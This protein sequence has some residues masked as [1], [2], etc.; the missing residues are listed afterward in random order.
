MR[1][2]LPG[3]ISLQRN[4]QFTETNITVKKRINEI[5]LR[6]QQSNV[7]EIVAQQG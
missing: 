2:A 4:K 1:E 6:T 7:D 3:H 5:S